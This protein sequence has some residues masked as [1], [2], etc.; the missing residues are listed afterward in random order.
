MEWEC[1]EEEGWTAVARQELEAQVALEVSVAAGEATVVDSEDVA[2][3][4][5]E[6]SVGPDVEG[7]PWTEWVAEAEE[8][9]AHQVERWI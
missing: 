5:G 2:V 8:G 6:A 9:W 7:H 3:W 1:V 4:I